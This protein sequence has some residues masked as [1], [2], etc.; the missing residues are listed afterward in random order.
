MSIAHPPAVPVIETERLI[1]R[2][3]RLEDFEA[4]TEMWA[5][6]ALIRFVAERK[7]FSREELWQRFLR[8]AGL[9]SVL[10][11]GFWA[12]EER[13][14]GL[15]VGSTGF[16]DMKRDIKPSLE[17]LPEA[18]WA[19]AAFAHRRGFATEMV[20]AMLAW[21]D[22][23]LDAEKTV[24]IIDPENAASLRVAE[25][26]GYREVLRTVYKDSPTILFERTRNVAVV[27]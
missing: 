26:C 22:R 4:M 27:G 1:L 6:P 17:G 19:L 24:C 5:D 9:W 16:H 25:K 21:S 13:A 2:G 3:H 15:Y 11:F 23:H 10:G 12:V 7:P 8:Y 18:G 14:S 20:L